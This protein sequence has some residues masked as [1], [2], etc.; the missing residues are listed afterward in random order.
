VVV[1]FALLTAFANAVSSIC[2]RLGVE[3]AP[4]TNGPSVGLIRHMV[5]RPIWLA[6]FVIMAGGYASQAV[7]LHVGSLNVVQ[8]LLV[9]ELVILVLVLWLWYRTPLRARDLAAAGATALGLALF[10]VFSSPRLGTKVPSGATWIMTSVVVVVVALGFVLVGSKGSPLRRALSLGAGASVGFALLAAIT[11]SM[12]DRLVAGWGPLFSSWQLY[13]LAVLG[14]S[15]FLIMQAAFQV[16]PFAAS[17]STLILVN[18]FVSIVVGR[19]L[20]GESLRGSPW[21]LTLEIASLLIMVLGALGLST[22]PLVA[23]VHE[24]AVGHHLLKGRGRYARWR[25][26]RDQDRTDL[27]S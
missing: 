14:L 6:G 5:Q 20:Y 17:Q 8:P 10:L 9:G 1:F 3:E 19:I 11:K 4:Q 24:E 25:A 16:G 13:A 12:T 2:Q 7:A 18:P 15:S 22:S 27:G 21:F 23:Q 26:Q